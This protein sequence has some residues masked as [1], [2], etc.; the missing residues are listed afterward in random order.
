MDPNRYV[1]D[2]HESLCGIV[3]IICH[4][5]NIDTKVIF[6]KRHDLR[7]VLKNFSDALYEKRN[8]VRDDNAAKL[9]SRLRTNTQW[10]NAV[11]NTHYHINDNNISPEIVAI[12]IATSIEILRANLRLNGISQTDLLDDMREKLFVA[13][14]SEY[15]KPIVPA[16]T[17]AE[18]LKIE[19]QISVIHD[20]L[21]QI[22]KLLGDQTAER[23]P[24]TA[25]P[26]LKTPTP[27]ASKKQRLLEVRADIEQVSRS[28]KRPLEGWEHIIQ[29]RRLND[30]ITANPKNSAELL[31]WVR[32]LPNFF[33]NEKVMTRQVERWGERI[34]FALQENT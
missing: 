27:I 16:S 12:C 24:T 33:G 4:S 23:S 6:H 8:Q 7:D 13:V 34:L 29:Y 10:L 5:A 22:A 26:T 15:G 1:R 25:L 11:L 30:L 20:K 21:D 28:A 32:T 31:S 19:D 2:I 9:L 3:E 18:L 17:S 14:F